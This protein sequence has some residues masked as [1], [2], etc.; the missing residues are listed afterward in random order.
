MLEWDTR[1]GEEFDLTL[2][3]NQRWVHGVTLSGIIAV[4]WMGTPCSSGSRPRERGGKGPPPLRS[5][6]HWMG[7]PDLS[8]KDAEKVRI[9]N[10]LM[11]FSASVFRLCSRL[12]IPC[13]IE[14]P[15]TSRLWGAPAMLQV[16]RLKA[17]S[18]TTSDF[19]QWGEQWRKRTGFLACHVNLS[20]ASRLCK[21]SGG[22]CS[23]TGEPH[24]ILE[25]TNEQDI[26]WTAV[27][28]PYPPRL[29][30]Q[31]VNSFADAL[32]TSTAKMQRY[33]LPANF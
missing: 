7:L 28:E 10:A 2:K 26:F 15:S 29:C 12:G 25:G 11:V 16:R 19:S 27:A 20:R 3:K 5:N 32:V 31:L 18:W 4:V 8:M 9:G 13:A 17:A 24:R 1:W 23:R 22:K 30:Q 6:Q 21:S 33:F 14:N